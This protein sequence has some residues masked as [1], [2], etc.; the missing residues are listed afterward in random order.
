MASGA[1]A[2]QGRQSGNE[3]PRRARSERTEL[4]LYRTA[5]WLFSERGFNGTS[6]RDIADAAE[7]AVSAMYYYAASK[8]ELLEGVMNQ[9]LNRL[10]DGIGEA[11]E[12]IS[13]PSERLA[14]I[15]GFHVAVHAYNPRTTRVIDDELRA[16]PAEARKRTLRLRDSYQAVW[17]E[18][19]IEGVKAKEFVPRGRIGRLALLEMCT[20]VAHWYR[21]RGELGVVEVCDR[22]A[23]M[24][25]ALLGARRDGEAVVISALDLPPA[26]RFRAMAQIDCEPKGKPKAA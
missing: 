5:T 10:V 11:L 8:D 9:G 23:D 20:G 22:F 12:G 6:I 24:A 3:S 2:K 15:V 21:P 18:V 13:G 16:L 17:D 19:L 14:T 7:L 1:R 25:L 26:E 4:H